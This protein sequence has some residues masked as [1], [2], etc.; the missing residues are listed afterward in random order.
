MIVLAAP[1][2]RCQGGGIATKVAAQQALEATRKDFVKRGMTALDLPSDGQ[3]ARRAIDKAMEKKEWCQAQEEIRAVRVSVTRANDV[4]AKVAKLRLLSAK[5]K[6]KAR[7]QM[8]KQ[9]TSAEREIEAGHKPV[10][11][12]IANAALATLARSKDPLWLPKSLDVGPSEEIIREVTFTADS[13]DADEVHAGCAEVDGKTGK[14]LALQSALDRLKASLDGRSVR[15]IDLKRGEEL[16]N[17]LTRAVKAR[18][19]ANAVKIACAMKQR[20]TQVTDDLDRSMARFSRVNALQEQHA[21]E[22]S[23]KAT[24][25]ELVTQAT[26]QIAARAYLDARL[27]LERLLIFLGDPT[28]PSGDIPAL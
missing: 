11:N 15:V 12:R 10:A 17:E 25:D 7:Q 8:N 24:F 5:L 26:S 20:A 28:E 22:D 23:A 13:L 4:S 19:L 3:N 14:G 16:N 18:E 27:T 21:I 2:G 9:L 6:G 1:A